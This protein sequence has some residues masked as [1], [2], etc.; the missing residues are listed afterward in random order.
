VDDGARAVIEGE[1]GGGP[2]LDVAPAGLNP[3]TAGLGGEAPAEIGD[4]GGDGD[5]ANGLTVAAQA[6]LGLEMEHRANGVRAEAQERPTPSVP[7]EL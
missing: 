7:P 4:F 6:L 2:V 1:Q 5:G 3:D